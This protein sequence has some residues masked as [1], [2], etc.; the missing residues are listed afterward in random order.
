[1]NTL[2]NSAQEI[3][4][5]SI[6]QTISS[7]EKSEQL[8]TQIKAYPD[9]T[10]DGMA[11]AWGIPTDQY[12][13]FRAQ[14][15]GENNPFMEEL[16]AVDGKLKS[17]DVILMTGTALQSKMLVAAQEK[18]F[19]RHA[20]SSHVALVHADFIC[21]DAMPGAGVS[22]R[23][24]HDVLTNVEDD[25]RVI[26]FKGI[27]AKHTEKLLKSASFY[28]AQPYKIKPSWK[29]GQHSAY[30]SELVRKIYRDCKLTGSGINDHLIVA[31]AHFD[32]LADK[33]PRW[34]DVTNDARLYLE[35][36]KKYSAM[37]NMMAKIF[38]DGLKL[39]RKRFE[40]RRKLLQLAQVNLSKKLISKDQYLD[41]VKTFKNIEDSMHHQFWDTG[42]PI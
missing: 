12:P 26:R 38:M 35:V 42:K 17:G 20:K 8:L 7:T 39:N 9:S 33:S 37:V 4:I 34:Q 29:S 14:V 5:S 10:L 3:A 22:N 1:M 24:L 2:Q 41:M 18:A 21:I 25:W 28:L 31:P 32:K 27:Q 16:S 30:C 40:H 15:R 13:I 6:L 36:C 19:Y 11:A 23:L